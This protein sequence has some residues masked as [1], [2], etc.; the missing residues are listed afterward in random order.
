MTPRPDSENEN[1]DVIRGPKSGLVIS[2]RSTLG[3]PV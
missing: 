1:E 2:Y 3:R